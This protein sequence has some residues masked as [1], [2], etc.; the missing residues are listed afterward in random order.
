VREYLD[1]GVQLIWV[2]HPPLRTV[3]VYRPDKSAHVLYEEDTL[4]GGD[5]LPEFEVQVAVI[6]DVD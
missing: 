1:F 4:D 3:T 5:V 6:F 2:V